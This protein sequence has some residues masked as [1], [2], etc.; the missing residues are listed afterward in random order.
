M[1]LNKFTIGV[2]SGLIIGVLFA[3]T[4]GRNSRK[5]ISKAAHLVNDKLRLWFGSDTKE[6]EELKAL[7]SDETVKLTDADR[8]RLVL[9]IEN[10]QKAI[11]ELD[12]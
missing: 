7:L 8:K 3:P 12:T 11:K 10:N 9:L 4:Q 5:T 6:L 2:A 1:K